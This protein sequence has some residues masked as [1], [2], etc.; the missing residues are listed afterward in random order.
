MN[1]DEYK[2]SKCRGELAAFLGTVAGRELISIL[3]NDAKP[4]ME[5]RKVYGT[6]E[7]VKMQMSINL[8]DSLAKN[9]IIDKIEFLSNPP[10]KSAIRKFEDLE[11]D[12]L[13]SVKQAKKKRKS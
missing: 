3:R 2:G 10:H 1:S 4:S 13:E 5:A 12:D 11:P 6:H 7:D 8:V 9:A